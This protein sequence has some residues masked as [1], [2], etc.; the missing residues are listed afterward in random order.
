MTDLDRGLMGD[1]FGNYQ[2]EI[3]GRGLEG[4]TPA[5][6]ISALELQEQAREHLSAGPYGYVAGG[7]GAELTMRANLA[8][9]ERLRIIPRMLR[10]V[11]AR[12]LSTT[13]LGTEMPAPVM[14]A[15]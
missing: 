11:S 6:P 9:F 4:K 12:E 3:Y 5:L 14:L 13:V 1:L 8:A 7:A 2:F 15:P 10:D